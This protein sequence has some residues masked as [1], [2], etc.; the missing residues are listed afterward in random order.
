MF[1]ELI[2]EV[3]GVSASS[4]HTT[5]VSS[6]I[7]FTHVQYLGIYQRHDLY[8]TRNHY[9]EILGTINFAYMMFIGILQSQQPLL[10]FYFCFELLLYYRIPIWIRKK[11]VLLIFWFVYSFYHVKYFQ[12]YVFCFPGHTYSTKWIFN[13]I[14]ISVKWIVM[15]IICIQIRKHYSSHVRLVI[16]EYRVCSQ[17]STKT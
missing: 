3:S 16:H 6:T 17:G 8:H 15:R 10:L 4:S 7:I 14:T 12:I 5:A 11:H 1:V 2:D 9:A 13:T